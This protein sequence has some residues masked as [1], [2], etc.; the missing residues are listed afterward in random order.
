MKHL[1]TALVLSLAVLGSACRE[2]APTEAPSGPALRP[3]ASAD[4]IAVTGGSG[5]GDASPTGSRGTN[6]FGSGN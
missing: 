4:S 2:S 5:T 1:R 3:A 6:T